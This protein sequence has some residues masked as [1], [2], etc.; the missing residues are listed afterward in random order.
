M[1]NSLEDYERYAS[2]YSSGMVCVPDSVWPILYQFDEP[3][4]LVVRAVTT[5]DMTA[6][7][8]KIR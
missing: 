7:G 5:D 2:D 4:N 8:E 6:A 3:Q 1:I